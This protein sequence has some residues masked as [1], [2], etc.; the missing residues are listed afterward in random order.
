M[1]N[2]SFFK[3]IIVLLMFFTLP[4][5]N[6]W[7]QTYISPI[8]GYD[9][10]K[11]ISSQGGIIIK[12]GKK[13]YSH[14]NPFIGIKIE[15]KL[16]KSIIF[17]YM[18]KFAYNKIHGY[19]Y[20]GIYTNDLIFKYYYIENSIGIGYLWRNRAYINFFRS[21]SIIQNMKIVDIKNH[22]D[23]ESPPRINEKGLK[24]SI[25]FKYKKLDLGMYYYKRTFTNSYNN[26]YYQFLD[27]ISSFGFELSYNFKIL[28][29][30]KIK[31]KE[32]CPDFKAKK[33]N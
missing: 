2:K 30:I 24:I 1:T 10:Q 6:N 9:F 31:K 13:G 28:N 26:T 5:N 20:G 19:N 27:G 8:L 18:G 32:E 21:Y 16:H 4:L 11:V 25:G 33:I 22:F 7:A 15:Q 23:T 3:I 17:N 29:G 14:I 12:F